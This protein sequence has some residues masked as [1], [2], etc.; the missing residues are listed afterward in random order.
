MYGRLLRFVAGLGLTLLLMAC[1]GGDGGSSRDINPSA[2]PLDA[3]VVGA[4]SFLTFPNPL[5]QTDGTIQTTSP[6]YAE[7]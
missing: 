1:G 2:P 4:D 6:A 5:V 7:A 3:V